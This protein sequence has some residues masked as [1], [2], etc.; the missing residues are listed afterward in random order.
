MRNSKSA[1]LLIVASRSRLK[2]CDQMQPL[3]VFF[4]LSWLS[5]DI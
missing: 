5:I 1:H 4:G 3:K 2:E